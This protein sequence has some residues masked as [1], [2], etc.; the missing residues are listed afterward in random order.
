MYKASG[1]GNLDTKRDAFD[2]LDREREK[3]KE[4]NSVPQW[5]VARKRKRRGNP[6]SR[7]KKGEKKKRE[8]HRISFWEGEKEKKG[9]KR[10][11][12]EMGYRSP[13]KGGRIRFSNIL[14]IAGVRKFWQK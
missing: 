12:K 14:R 4:R 7:L 3:E 5:G 10:E 13:I 8:E 11:K 2:L 9:T 1:G 6:F